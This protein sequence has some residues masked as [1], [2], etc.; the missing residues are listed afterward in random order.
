VSILIILLLSVGAVLGIRPFNLF[1]FLQSKTS[2]VVLEIVPDWHGTGMDAFVGASDGSPDANF[3][4]HAGVPVSF[5]ITNHDTIVNHDFTMLAPD[6]NFTVM[7][8]FSVHNS[9]SGVTTR[10]KQGQIVNGMLAGDSFNVLTLSIDVPA[11]PGAVVTFTYTFTQDGVYQY[12]S[13]LGIMGCMGFGY[14]VGS[15]TVKG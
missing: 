6:Q 9:T 10:Y 2:S 5:V 11:P 13:A 12:Y 14:T 3:I 15:I 4:V 8:E 1:P 7:N